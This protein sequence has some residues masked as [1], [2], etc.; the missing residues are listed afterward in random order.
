MERRLRHTDVVII[1]SRRSVRGQWP[2]RRCEDL[3]EKEVDPNSSGGLE[4][5]TATENSSKGDR[6]PNYNGC[7]MVAEA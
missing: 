7:P 3:S 2:E 4:V 6:H 1:C 5:A